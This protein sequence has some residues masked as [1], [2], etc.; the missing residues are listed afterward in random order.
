[1]GAEGGGEVVKC[2]VIIGGQQ[3][4]IVCDKEREELKLPEKA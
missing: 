1:M 4:M 2:D 3:D